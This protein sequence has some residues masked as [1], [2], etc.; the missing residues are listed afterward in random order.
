MRQGVIGVL[1]LLTVLFDSCFCL[2]GK[3]RLALKK[4]YRGINIEELRERLRNLDSSASVQNTIS[5]TVGQTTLVDLTSEDV[6]DGQ[7]TAVDDDSILAIN[8]RE[9]VDEYLYGGDMVLTEE[10][11]SALEHP[12]RQKRQIISSS[13]RRW[14]NNTVFYYFDVDITAANQDLVRAH[15]E[16]ISSRTCLKFVENANATNRIKVIDGGGC[17]SYVGM[18]RSEQ[19]L[20]LAN[21]CFSFMDTPIKRGTSIRQ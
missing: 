12:T 15:L 6:L 20:S 9:G 2:P 17:W 10:Q 1:V 3:G 4:A 19:Q 18:L 13:T 14:E 21:G 16:Y 7:S 5:A 11:L 8:R